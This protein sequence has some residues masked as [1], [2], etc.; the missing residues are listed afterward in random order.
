ME[1]DPVAFEEKEKAK[2]RGKIYS[3]KELRNMN[4]VKK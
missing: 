4:D 1:E 3:Y 2:A